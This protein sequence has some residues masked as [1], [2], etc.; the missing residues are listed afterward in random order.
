MVPR[1]SGS[2]CHATEGPREDDPKNDLVLVVRFSICV[3]VGVSKPIQSG[4]VR[5]VTLQN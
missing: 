3:V 1:E 4:G 5:A 2:K